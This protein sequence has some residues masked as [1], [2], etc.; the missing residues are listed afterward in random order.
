MT[1]H[2]LLLPPC[3]CNK[4]LPR[5]LDLLH[6]TPWAPH[7]LRPDHPLVQKQLPLSKI[8]LHNHS[9]VFDRRFNFHLGHLSMPL[10]SLPLP[11]PLQMRPLS[12]SQNLLQT[13]AQHRL[14]SHPLS[15]KKWREESRRSI[16]SLQ[17]TQQTF[18]PIGQKN[19]AQL[20]C[21]HSRTAMLL[22]R[23]KFGS[24]M[25]SLYE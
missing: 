4:K 18:L 3:S 14:T 6:D 13:C 15:A 25:V 16:A 12:A 9:P 23:V 20:A 8:I 7:C 1:S 22:R 5:D 10:L 2:Q 11:S 21:N 19:N 24:L 17:K